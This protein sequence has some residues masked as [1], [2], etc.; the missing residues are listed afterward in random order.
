MNEL[1]ENA[2]RA[3]D[4]PGREA[5]YATFCIFKSL[6]SFFRH[7]FFLYELFFSTIPGP[8]AK[9]AAAL[10]IHSPPNISHIYPLKRE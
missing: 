6:I 2:A 4:R 9:V 5:I 3:A 7:E 1:T 8:G 10:L